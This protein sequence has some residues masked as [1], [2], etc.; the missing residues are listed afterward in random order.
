MFIHYLK[1][2][3]RNMRKY[4]NQTLISIVGLAVG[5]TCFALATL[6]IRYEITF[7]G[8][9]KN[10]KHKYV[11]YRPDTR[12]QT[13]YNSWTAYALATYLKETFPEIAEAIPLSSTNRNA[14]VEVEGER[15]PA[16]T[17]SADTS[18]FRMFDIKILGIANKV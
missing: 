14:L 8:F 1:I 6:W 7:D 15:I 5:F 9:H 12:N 2:A 16:L 17:I 4:F 18:F 10:A 3:F 11:I 13:G